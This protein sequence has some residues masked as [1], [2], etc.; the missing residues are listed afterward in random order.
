MTPGNVR[1]LGLKLNL[2]EWPP[3]FSAHDVDEEVNLFTAN[4]L[5]ILNE[6]LPER[7]VRVGPTDKPWMTPRIKKEIRARQSAYTI[8]DN[9]KYKQL[10]DKVSKPIAR[11]KESYYP[12]KDKGHCNSNPAKWYRMIYGLAAADDS[13]SSNPPAENQQRLLQL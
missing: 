2:E 6:T 12:S 13:R 4:L 3:V 7:K 5:R 11:A 9:A 8:G 1:A 10:C